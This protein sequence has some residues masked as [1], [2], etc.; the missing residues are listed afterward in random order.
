M[1]MSTNVVGIIPADDKYKKMKAIYDLCREQDIDVPTEVSVFFNEDEPDES[2]MVVDL[3]DVAH[4]WSD[5]NSEGY[6]IDIDKI[7]KNIKTIRF[8]NSW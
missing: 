5:E 6:E 1:S 4:K 2:G 8:Y 3:E 7:P